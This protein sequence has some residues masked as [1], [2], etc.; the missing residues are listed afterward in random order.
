LSIRPEQ[1]IAM[2]RFLGTLV[3][4][5]VLVVAIAYG[6]GWFSITTDHEPGKFT[7]SVEIY[8]GKIKSATTVE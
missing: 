5:C 2:S 4:V 8:T 3:V 1:V 6:F 7:T